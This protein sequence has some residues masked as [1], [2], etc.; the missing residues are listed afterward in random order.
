VLF[1]IRVCWSEGVGNTVE[2]AVRGLVGEGR[3]SVVSLVKLQVSAK[4]LMG[5]NELTIACSRFGSH[6]V[7]HMS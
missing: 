1:G 4:A 7:W 3:M 5:S 6:C 2:P